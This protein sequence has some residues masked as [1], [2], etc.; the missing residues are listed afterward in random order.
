MH[1][2]AAYQP[3]CPS[4]LLHALCRSPG[5]DIWQDFQ[6]VGGQSAQ[7]FGQAHE[8]WWQGDGLPMQQHLVGSADGGTHPRIGQSKPGFGDLLHPFLQTTHRLATSVASLYLLAV[9]MLSQTPVLA[10]PKPNLAIVSSL[11]ADDAQSCI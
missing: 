10:S 2:T 8:A 11:F 7:V 4:T 6:D 9:L 3:A 5:N 1:A